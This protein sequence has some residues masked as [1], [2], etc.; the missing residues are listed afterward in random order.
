M[1]IIIAFVAFVVLFAAMALGVMLQGKPLRGSC[2]GISALMG[3]KKCELCG[4]SPQLCEEMKQQQGK[5]S[6]KEN[7]AE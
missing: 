4:G 6:E 1:E 3:T 2:G 7:S 5:G